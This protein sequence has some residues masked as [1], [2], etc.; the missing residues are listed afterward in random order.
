[1]PH[2]LP[3]KI[4][5]DAMFSHER[6]RPRITQRVKIS[7]AALLIP[8]SHADALASMMPAASR[9]LAAMAVAKHETGAKHPNHQL[10]EKAAKTIL[11][12]PK[13]NEKA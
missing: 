3:R 2:L 8:I 1:M 13:A 10:I 5:R 4:I 7:V 9:S 12:S 6:R 11:D